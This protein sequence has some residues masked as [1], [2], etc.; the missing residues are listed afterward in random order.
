MHQNKIQIIKIKLCQ[1]IMSNMS[2]SICINQPDIPLELKEKKIQVI[3]K[4]IKNMIVNK[5][6][7]VIIIYQIILN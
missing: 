5:L 2:Y 7:V 1:I 6:N 4:A 3:L